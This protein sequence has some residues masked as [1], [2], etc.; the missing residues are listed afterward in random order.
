MT[1]KHNFQDDA[2]LNNGLQD[3]DEVLDIDDGTQVS[4]ILF[5][6]TIN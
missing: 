5:F 2:I 3:T 4:V 6:K 1:L